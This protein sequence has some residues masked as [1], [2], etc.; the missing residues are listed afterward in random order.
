[1]LTIVCGVLGVFDIQSVMAQG[2][3]ATRTTFTRDQTN[4]MLEDYENS[5][6][7]RNPQRRRSAD[8][9]A[10]STPRNNR[11]TVD[12][13]TIRPLIRSFST[14]ASELVYAINDE[15]RRIPALKAVYK[16]ALL[17]G[18]EAS[19]LDKRAAETN[20]SNQLIDDFQAV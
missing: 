3:P 8:D 16:D 15:S 5:L 20:D 13:K 10:L 11:T 19:R 2:I 9:S 4:R 6:N 1:M 14:D 17:V 12:V 18:A 7:I